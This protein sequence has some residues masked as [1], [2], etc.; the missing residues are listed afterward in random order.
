VAEVVVVVAA[1]AASSLA[2]ASF[3]PTKAPAAG[4]LL[5]TGNSTA[6]PALAVALQPAPL[7][8]PIAPT[9]TASPYE[10]DNFA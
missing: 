9:A 4:A 5:A 7:A 3:K 6:P 10:F 2:A 1:V 8:S